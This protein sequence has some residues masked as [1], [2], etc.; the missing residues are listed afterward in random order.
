MLE[1]FYSHIRKEKL[2]KPSDSILLAVSGGVDSVVMCDLFYKAKYKFSIAHCNF[3]LRGKESDDD[4]AFV[5][6][7]AEK[8][9]VT[10][11]SIQFDTAA[12]A[13]KNKVSIQIAARE[14]RYRW[15]QELIKEYD[16]AFLATAHHI[17]DSVETFFINLIRGAGITGLH[18]ILPKSGNIIR[19]M[20][21]CSK[22]DIV[23]YA[24]RHKLKYREDSSNASDKYLRNKLRLKII[25]QLQEINPEL[26][27][28][29]SRTIKH[30]QETE[31]IY[32]KEIERNR[33]R[34]V[35]QD[36]RAI[37]I[38]IKQLKALPAISTHL[39]EFL[40]PF[41]FNESTVEEINK[42]LDG[43]SGRLFFSE[44]HRLIKDREYLI[45][46]E[47]NDSNV[48]SSRDKSIALKNQLNKSVEGIQEN[49]KQY[50]TPHFKM[51]FKKV[52][53]NAVNE[54]KAM[55][56]ASLFT[57]YLDYDKLQFPLE[58]RTWKQ[59]DFFYPLGLKGKKKLSDFFTDKKM[60]V[61]D[62]ENTWLLTCNNQIVWV[63]G[64]RTDDR[65]KLTEKTKRI[66]VVDFQNI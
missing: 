45:V 35:K 7:L 33:K 3:Q 57:A 19:P 37:Y 30:L 21:F 36:K 47:L 29:V 62:K 9:N 4:E 53:K 17:G 58:V 1:L 34:I 12:Y 41:H 52:L 26:E 40:K 61:A 5:E 42:S 38:S 6:G 63:M 56:N 43:E 8:Y 10:F 24:K 64:W 28:S 22:K 14:L 65:F 18:G 59:G 16:Y 2:I 55:S 66:Y 48:S 39:F 27:N 15:F 32:K 50:L 11:H 25:P 54:N 31:T 13:K 20:L 60:S 44:S 46:Q 51:S 23:A 49:Q